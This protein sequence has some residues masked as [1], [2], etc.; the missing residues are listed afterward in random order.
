[1][2]VKFTS[3]NWQESMPKVYTENISTK[4]LILCLP[5]GNH[6]KKT[7]GNHL[8]N[9]VFVMPNSR[10]TASS[11]SRLNLGITFPFASFF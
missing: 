8:K 5:N 4:T 1:M 7:N 6:S 10:M 11:T 2:L 9:C 3:N